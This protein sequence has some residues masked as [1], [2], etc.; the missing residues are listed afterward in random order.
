MEKGKKLIKNSI[1]VLIGT[2]LTKCLNFIMAPLFTRWLSPEDYGMFDLIVMYST[3]L[4]PVIAVGIHHALFRYL[5]DG[6]T[7]SKIVTINTNALLINIIGFI[8]YALLIIPLFIFYTNIRSYIIL[9]TI[10]FI[11]QSAYNYLE[12]FARGL[13]KLKLYS[14]ANII[15]T[16]STLVFVYI[17]V[18]KYNMGLNGIIFGYS[19]GYLVSS[20]CILTCTNFF[21]YLNKNYIDKKQIKEMIKYS[22]P[23]IPNSIAWWLVNLSDR[24]IVNIFLGPLYN[25][26]LAV[27]HKLPNICVTLYEGFQTAWVENASEAIKDSDW[28]DYFNMTLNIL[29]RLSISISIVIIT[30]NFFV[31]NFLFTEE[32]ILGKSLVPLFAIAIIFNTLSQ[33]IGSVFIAEYNSKEQGKTMIEAGIINIII[34]LLLIKYLGIYASVISTI[35]AYLFLFIIRF[36]SIKN[37]YVIKF[38]IKTIIFFALLLIFAI[39]SYFDTAWINYSSLLISFLVC[40]VFNYDILKAILHKFIRIPKK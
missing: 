34:H 14:I 23:M 3:F 36:I 27:A 6:D 39:L 10:L 32:Y 4:I 29:C 33:T 30:T 5:L 25:A 9:L 24:M 35:V 22:L 1:I 16:F 31:Y 17:F 38:S 19:I 15:C 37:K 8:I 13:K 20:L 28:N 26:I 11:F 7:K 21:R 40:L 18:K 2:I 12:M